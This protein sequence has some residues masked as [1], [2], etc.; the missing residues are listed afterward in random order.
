MITEY[1]L[2]KKGGLGPKTI[3]EVLK[4]PRIESRFQLFC[5]VVTISTELWGFTST[6]PYVSIVWSILKYHEDHNFLHLSTSVLEFRVLNLFVCIRRANKHKVFLGF[7][8]SRWHYYEHSEY[9]QRLHS[10]MH[11]YGFRHNSCCA[12]STLQI[13][14][15]VSFMTASHGFRNAFMNPTT[16]YFKHCEHIQ[17]HVSVTFGNQLPSTLCLVWGT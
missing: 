13:K 12:S 7:V 9:T 14:S 10:S 1:P 5:S 3:L 6:L 16:I 8:L 4:K 15:L 17:Q 2:V 11:A